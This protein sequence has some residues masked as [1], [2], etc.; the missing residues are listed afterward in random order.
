MDITIHSFW[1]MFLFPSLISMKLYMYNYIKP[2]RTIQGHIWQQICRLILS[3]IFPI[4]WK[5]F[6]F[7][8]DFFLHV[9]GIVIVNQIQQAFSFKLGLRIS[10]VGQLILISFICYVYRCTCKGDVIFFYKILHSLAVNWQVHSP[11]SY[12]IN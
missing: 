4:H 1:N 9:L 6:L 5:K 3:L 7:H 8:N 10:I 12:N 11:N 2:L